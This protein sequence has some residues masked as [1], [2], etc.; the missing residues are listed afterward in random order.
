MHFNIIL[1]L[2]I[3]KICTSF[4]GFSPSLTLVLSNFPFLYIIC[5]VL[6]LHDNLTK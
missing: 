5:L 4:I 1:Y 6:I 3:D 2:S